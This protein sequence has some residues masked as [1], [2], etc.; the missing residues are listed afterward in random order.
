MTD[1]F[2]Q[3]DIDAIAARLPDK[4]RSLFLERFAIC[5]YDG[6]LPAAVALRIALAEIGRK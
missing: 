1:P 5:H 6:K 4:D 3:S 2:R